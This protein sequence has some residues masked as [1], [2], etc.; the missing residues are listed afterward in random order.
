MSLR[1][2]LTL[3]YSAVSA[4]ILL[5]GG[6]AFFFALRQSLRQFL[7]DSLRE[8]TTFAASQLGGDERKP[9]FTEA[10]NDLF[11]TRLPGSI[12]LRLFEP[13]GQETD[14]FGISRVKAPLIEGFA[15][16]KN[17]RVYTLR[18]SNGAWVQAMRPELETLETLSRAQR[19]LF[20]GLPLLLLLGLGAGYLLADRALKPVDLVAGLA[21]KIANS[22]RYQERVPVAPGHDEMARLIQTVNAMLSRLE[23]T[24]ER[25]KAFALAAAH[26]LR[27]PLSLLQGRA[28]LSLEKERS[29]EQ[30][31]EALKQV[32]ATSRELVE[33]VE[34][35]LALARTNQPPTRVPINLADIALEV[36]EAQS[37][38]ARSRNMRLHVE[39]ISAPT[40]GDPTMLRL[41]ISNLVQ[42]AIKF[43]RV[44]GNVWVSNGNSAGK[45]WIAVADDGPGIPETE[46]QRLLQPFE[47]G[48]GLQAVG[49]TGLGL[50]LATAIA[51]Q[52]DG[53]VELSR[54]EQGGL[55]AVLWL[56][57]KPEVP[58]K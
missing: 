2:R 33:L 41:G 23:S 7:D 32:D 56:P 19:L 48:Q 1:W 55:S 26:E 4:V 49:G 27:T 43:G 54:S 6:L 24:I 30:Y 8:A 12:V 9:R 5:I 31:R 11:Q 22:G 45:A 36:V 37:D 35:L 51:E 50:A 44:G 25:E 40:I 39:L 58:V 47:R 38:F 21:S 13:S 28:S 14:R 52:H 3:Y 20:V 42:N 57:T 16:V 15:S 34:K 17:E 46:L 18:L 53:R 10:E 29:S